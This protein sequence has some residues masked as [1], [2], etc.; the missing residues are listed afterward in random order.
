MAVN[1]FTIG[2][3]VRVLWVG[4]WNGTPPD[5]RILY[6]IDFPGVVKECN[7][8]TIGVEIDRYWDYGVLQ[9]LPDELAVLDNTSGGSVE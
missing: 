3:R 6:L 2:Q 4:D 8:D 7:S 9:F 5:V 1:K